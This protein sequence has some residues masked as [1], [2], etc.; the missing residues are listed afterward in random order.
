MFR[1]E[2]IFGG[3]DVIIDVWE[4]VGKGVMVSLVMLN[5]DGKEFSGRDEGL[6]IVGD[7][8]GGMLFVVFGKDEGLKE[9][10]FSCL[11]FGWE[12]LLMFCWLRWSCVLGLLGFLI[13]GKLSVWEVGF[14]K[15]GCGVL[16][17]DFLLFVC[18][19]D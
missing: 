8:E 4:L 2:F 16:F 9:M 5:E 14:C 3:R 7:D 18:V 1:I 6:V 19:N 12:G 10:C 11:V 17:E 15:L 13:M